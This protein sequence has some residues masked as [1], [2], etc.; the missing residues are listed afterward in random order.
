MRKYDR[1]CVGE[2]ALDDT[3]RFA[4]VA[5]WLYAIHKVFT[6]FSWQNGSC[7]KW[8]YPAIVDLFGFARVLCPRVLR[9]GMQAGSIA[10]RFIVRRDAGWT[11]PRRLTLFSHVPF[12]LVSR[13]A[14]V[15]FVSSDDP[16]VT[17]EM[18]Q[19]VPILC[20]FIFTRM[21]IMKTASSLVLE[22]FEKSAI[23]LF[24]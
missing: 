6:G 22:S 9:A 24:I 13:S 20:K 23:L 18:T 15:D 8:I 4:D 7:C 1:L 21:K 5:A 3:R 10:G 11:T 19:N 2:S 16:R 12:I 14:I 17:K